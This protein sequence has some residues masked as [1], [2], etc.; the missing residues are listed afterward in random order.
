MKVQAQFWSGKELKKCSFQKSHHQGAFKE[1]KEWSG[2]SSSCS[3]NPI[4]P[5]GGTRNI[6]G[7]L[8]F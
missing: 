5:I 6:F 7:F 8:C 1:F 3:F 4:P 2:C